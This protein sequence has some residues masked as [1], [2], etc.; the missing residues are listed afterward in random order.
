MWRILPYGC[1]TDPDT[2]PWGC[3]RLFELRHRVDESVP[4]QLSKYAASPIRSDILIGDIRVS[5]RDRHSC[6]LTRLVPRR[7]LGAASLRPGYSTTLLARGSRRH[8]LG[9]CVIAPGCPVA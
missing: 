1:R 4:A 8:G 6:E 9:G 3:P 5:P 2:T 7:W